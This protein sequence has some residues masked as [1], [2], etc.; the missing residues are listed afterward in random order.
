MNRAYTVAVFSVPSKV[1]DMIGAQCGE[2]VIMVKSGP[3]KYKPFN[4]W[5]KE[6]SQADTQSMK[7]FQ[8]S[9]PVSE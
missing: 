7:T 3:A 9:K 6:S 8:W 2:L 4:Y 5:I 1:T